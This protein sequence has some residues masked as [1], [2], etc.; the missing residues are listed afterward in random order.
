MS[1]FSDSRPAGAEPAPRTCQ[2]RRGQ[3]P[4]VLQSTEQCSVSLVT[5]VFGEAPPC[6][7]AG[8]PGPALRTLP[9]PGPLPRR[10]CCAPSSQEPLYLP[11]VR[12]GTPPGRAASAWANQT[13]PLRV[14][15]PSGLGAP[16]GG[17]HHHA[18]GGAQEMPGQDTRCARPQP[19]WAADGPDAARP[20]PQGVRPASPCSPAPAATASWAGAGLPCS[21]ST[22]CCGRSRGTCRR[23]AGGRSC[24]WP[25]TS[26]RYRPHLGP[27]EWEGGGGGGALWGRRLL[28]PQGGRERGRAILAGRRPSRPPALGLPGASS[29]PTC[30]RRMGVQ[31]KIM[32]PGLPSRV[33]P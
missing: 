19:P 24:T 17:P 7:P 23:C 29:F 11:A 22:R 27:R 8:S 25:W 16:R 14:W 4:S 1:S 20:L 21:T 31:L 13:A 26:R 30:S 32:R 2:P 28:N 33:P 9:P 3:D 6:P 5:C 10:S 18:P 12:D 15:V